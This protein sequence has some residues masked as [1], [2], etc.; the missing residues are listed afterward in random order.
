MNKSQYL[1][2][3]IALSMVL[4]F[5]TSSFGLL[6]TVTGQGQI[7]TAPANVFDD[8]VN[9]DE[10]GSDPIFADQWGF[11]EKQQVLLTSDLMVDGGMIAAG[12][13]VSSHMIFLNTE[14]GRYQD[15]EA[16]WT[17]SDEIL[18]V[19]SDSTGQLEVDSSDL[20]GNPMT[21]YPD[22]PFGARGLENN[23]AYSAMANALY[24]HMQVTEPGDWIRVITA[25]KPIPEPGTMMLLGIGL[26]GGAYLRRRRTQ[27]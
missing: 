1:S 8:G 23:D 21:M 15:T 11:D 7:V 4:T 18:G 27:R 12:T 3:L 9:T 17:F 20:L 25:A 16:T 10:P 14:G 22:M 2:I 13:W 19:M 24:V 6:M 5:A 26:I